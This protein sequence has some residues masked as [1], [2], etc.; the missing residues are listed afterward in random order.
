LVGFRRGFL[1]PGWLGRMILGLLA[2]GIVGNLIDRVRLGYVVD[3]LDFHWH[4]H[5]FPAFNVA[6]ASICIGVG[7][8]M[9]VHLRAGKAR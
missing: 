2:G 1:P 7:L 5:H 6:D 9:V 4:G 3:Y 8:Y